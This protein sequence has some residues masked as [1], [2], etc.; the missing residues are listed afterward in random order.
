MLPITPPPNAHDISDASQ[1]N[2]QITANP[3][4]RHILA[5]GTAYA[6]LMLDF[7]FGY[8]MGERAAAKAS[9]FSRGAAAA[10]GAGSAVEIDE[11]DARIDRLVLVV[12]SM[13]SLLK[14]HGYTDEQLGARIRSIDLEDGEADSR[15]RLQPSRCSACNSLVEP[16]RQSCTYCGAPITSTAGPIE[17]V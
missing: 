17:S 12:H 9:L 14:E 1:E 10:Q 5:P 2:R 11:L 6:R 4:E 15:R 13:W 3:G 8:V 7:I 16:G